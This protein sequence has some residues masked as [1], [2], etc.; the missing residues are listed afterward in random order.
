M[1]PAIG[2]NIDLRQLRY[3]V[4]VARAGSFT[5]AAATLGISP[6]TL[7]MKLRRWRGADAAS[8]ESLS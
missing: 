7:H 5:R 6:K 8:A 3:F 2:R 1:K 4:A